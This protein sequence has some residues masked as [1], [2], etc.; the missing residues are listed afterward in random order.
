MGSTERSSNWMNEPA[1]KIHGIGIVR[2]R[3]LREKGRPPESAKQTILLARSRM[4]GRDRGRSTQSLVHCH[5]PW[6]AGPQAVWPHGHRARATVV[7]P[8][9]FTQSYE[10]EENRYETM[11][12]SSDDCGTGAGRRGVGE[13]AGCFGGGQGPRAAISGVDE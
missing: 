4:G 13:G 11:L 7:R 9:S 12:C 1:Q 10:R 3:R 8:R 2:Q 6:R 5:A